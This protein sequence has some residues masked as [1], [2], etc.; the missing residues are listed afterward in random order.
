MKMALK[1]VIF[2]VLLYGTF[3]LYR[4]FLLYEEIRAV[5]FI[6][7]AWLFCVY[8]TLLYFEV[9]S[10]IQKATTQQQLRW[11]GF[12]FTFWVSFLWGILFASRGLD[13]IVYQ[14]L[15]LFGLLV[16]AA[17]IGALFGVVG[18]AITQF[19]VLFVFEQPEQI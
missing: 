3:L 14:P 11:A 16:A 1:V 18:M 6:F 12:R 19:M 5:D 7:C 15:D 4:K 13:F 9:R 10:R 2:G 8:L 17:M